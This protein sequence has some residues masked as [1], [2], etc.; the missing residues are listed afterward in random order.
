M[1]AQ[2][3]IKLRRGTAAQWTSTNPVLAAGEIGLE[4]DTLRTKY[5]NG[6][7][8]WTALSYS[9]ADASGTSS[10]DWTS[11]L[12][13]PSTF[14]PSTHTHVASDITNIQS[15]VD[16]RINLVIDGAPAALDTLNE[17]A[18]ALGDDAN[19]AS[20]VT[21]SLAGK[22]S[23]VHTHTIANVTGLQTALDGK[24]NT[25]HTHTMQQVHDMPHPFLLMGA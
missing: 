10:V 17:L 15:Y 18:A 11:V 7:S 20:T 13:K 2:T 16:G 23:T 9:V 19:F 14:P 8:T 3:V 4:T 24:A 25:S 21:T 5:G 6:T 12:N 1:P 22:A